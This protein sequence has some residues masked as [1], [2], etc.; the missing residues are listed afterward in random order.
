MSFSSRE[1]RA[2]MGRFATGV[3]VVTTCVGEQRAGITVNAFASLSLDPPLVLIALD[4][5]SALYELVRTSGIFA[6]NILGA[7]QDDISA[8]FARHSEYR[9]REFCG[10]LTHRE[11]TG[12]PVFNHCL[13][14]VDCR[15]V[16]VYPGGDHGI[17]VGHVEALGV[18]DE[19]EPLLYYRGQYPSMEPHI[20]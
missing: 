14:W 12:A 17:F 13:G 20:Q 4:R 6:V 5:S 16:D 19:Q 9:L 18:G 1:F 7:S 11:S 3:T 15:L 8:C 10:V 2:V